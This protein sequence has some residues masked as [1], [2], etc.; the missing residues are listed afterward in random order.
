MTKR[1]FWFVLG[2]VAFMVAVGLWGCSRKTVYVPME[3]VKTEYKEADTT[4]IFNRFLRLFESQ[5]Q[6]EARSDSLID[7]EKE[8]VV[9]NENGDTTKH[10]KTQYVYASIKHEKELEQ[11]LSEKDSVIDA[12]RTQLATQQTDT[13]RVPYP[14]ERDLTKWEKVKMDFGGFAIGGL[15]ASAVVIALSAWLARKRRK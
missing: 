10:F 14:V 15:C 1:F 13:V 4:A 8:T 6:K 2:A 5:K 7:R 9:L 3:S 11:K 12:L